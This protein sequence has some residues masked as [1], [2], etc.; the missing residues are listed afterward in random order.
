MSRCSTHNLC[1]EIRN[2]EWFSTVSLRFVLSRVCAFL[3]SL[4]PRPWWYKLSPSPFWVFVVLAKS[5]A[6]ITGVF[7][8]QVV[9]VP[10]GRRRSN[11][12]A[13]RAYR[14]RW[15]HN[16][17]LTRRLG[18]R[19]GV[20]VFFAYK[21]ELRCELVRGSNYS[22]VDTKVWYISRDDRARIATCSLRTTTD[23]F[24]DNCSIDYHPSN[25]LD[26]S[27]QGNIG[28]V[29]GVPCT[30]LSVICPK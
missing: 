27:G 21:A 18:F 23:K 29:D 12:S 4:G 17:T 5:V 2:F 14:H 19:D 10:T 24:K 7:A 6:T 26:S 13:V 3:Y 22:R 25:I 20:L 1:S 9:A 16:W 30:T 15:F 8:I 11:V 28:I